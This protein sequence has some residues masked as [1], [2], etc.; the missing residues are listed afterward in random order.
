MD[1][2]T[3]LA[4]RKVFTL[5]EAARVLKPRGGK[6]GA[7]ERLLYHVRKG[8]LKA[9]ARGVYATVP[10]GVNAKDF[11]PDRYLVAMAVRPDAVFCYHA[12]LELLGAAHSEWTR[13]T[14]FT[15]R[16]RRPLELGRVRMEFLGHPPPLGARKALT[17]GVRVVDRAGSDLHVTGPERTLV[18]GFRQPA[19]VGGV[20][21]LVESAS[22]LPVLDLS[23][24]EQVL[25][26]YADR[27][28]Y[29][30]VG[31][32][33][34]RFRRTFSVPPKVLDALRKRRPKS[35]HYLPRGQ[36]GGVMAGRWNLILS[37]AAAGYGEPDE[38]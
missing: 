23:L 38:R 18:E 8:R 30:A 16:R 33:L 7:L 12:A 35:P 36:R 2:A 17:L 22:G 21:E 32:F 20:E 37:E 3:F 5:E 29:A 11:Q 10:P 9:V 27:T 24:L 14:V 28:A 1:T 4:T 6:R 19:R 34:E 26:A 15:S 31:W 13:C 25:Q